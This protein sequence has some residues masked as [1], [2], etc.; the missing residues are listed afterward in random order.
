MLTTTPQQTHP[1]SFLHTQ[2][3]TP[4]CSPLCCPLCPDHHPLPANASLGQ[5]RNHLQPLHISSRLVLTMKL[6]GSPAS[7][8][9]ASC[10]LMGVGRLEPNQ[11]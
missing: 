4:L 10:F 7:T 1:M 6:R 3:T 9:T 11:K 5:L 2:A 8:V